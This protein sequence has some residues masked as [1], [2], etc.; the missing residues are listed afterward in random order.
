[1]ALELFGRRRTGAGVTLAR[2]PL[3]MAQIIVDRLTHQ[4]G[5]ALLETAFAEDT[6]DFGLS[7]KPW[8]VTF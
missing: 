6:L 5:L 1:M 2:D 4:T 7:P 3:V 8:R